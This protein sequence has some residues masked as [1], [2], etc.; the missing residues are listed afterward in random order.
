MSKCTWCDKLEERRL[1]FECCW[2]DD[3]GHVASYREGQPRH[4]ATCIANFCPVCGRKLR[5]E[6]RP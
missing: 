4:I 5:K 3:D 2:I 1:R 6:E